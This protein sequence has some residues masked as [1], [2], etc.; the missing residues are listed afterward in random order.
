MPAYNSASVLP[1]SL[2]FLVQEAESFNFECEVIVVNDGSTDQTSEILKDFC[3]NNQVRVCTH[4]KN[5]GPAATRNTG[6]IASKGDVIVFVDSDILV[7]EGFIRQHLDNL[8]IS[9][10]LPAAPAKV[11]SSGTLVYSPCTDREKALKA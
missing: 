3:K 7:T 11:I 10:I 8:D 1:N 9:D 4:P 6:F 5:R 2:G